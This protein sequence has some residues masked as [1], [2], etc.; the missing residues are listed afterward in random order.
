MI[1]PDEIEWI[2]MFDAHWEQKHGQWFDDPREKW[3]AKTKARFQ[4][5]W[6][7]WWATLTVEEKQV[8]IS[9]NSLDRKLRAHRAREVSYE[10]WDAEHNPPEREDDGEPCR[11]TDFELLWALDRV[12]C[13]IIR[14]PGLTEGARRQR[15][16]RYRQQLSDEIGQPIDRIRLVKRLRELE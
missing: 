9:L 1:T 3:L 4:T 14:S 5:C 16:V 7:Q 15:A 13:N 12:P 11:G 2:A 6:A 10:A 8:I